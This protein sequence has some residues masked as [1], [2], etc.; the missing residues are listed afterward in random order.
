MSTSD[1]GGGAPEHGQQTGFGWPQAPVGQPWLGG[2]TDRPPWEQPADPGD[3][4][5][6]ERIHPIP[7][8][9]QQPPPPASEP[10]QPVRSPLP[11]AELINREPE[12]SGP[13]RRILGATRAAGSRS[14]EQH[15]PEEVLARLRAPIAPAQRIAVTSV[16][17]GAGKTAVSAL[18]GS[19]LAERRQDPVLALD[20]AEDAGS[21]AWRLATSADQ[22]IPAMTDLAP[23]LRAASGQGL[24]ALAPVLART[25]TGLWV[26]PGGNGGQAHLARDL[27][28]TLAQL[29]AVEVLDCGTGMTAPATTSVLTDAHAV[30]IT[31]P[32]TPDGVRTTLTAL[33]RAPTASLGRVVVALNRGAASGDALA[34]SAAESAFARYSIPVVLL[35]HDRHLAGGTPI[36]P[37][38]VA[39]SVRSAVARLAA[40][41][42][43]RAQ[44]L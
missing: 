28:R 15:E 41:V 13:L 8:P 26:L 6:T 40:Q 2:T 4:E 33:H 36:E 30:V 31:V 19:V 17:G 43:G 22:P 24:G 10:V 39:P 20:A 29:F 11:G 1:S 42:L 38:R 25:A 5:S 27:A 3:P 23:T 44:Q 16:R 35:P 12:N 21:L 14:K 7:N 32:A 18:L 9:Y 34:L 37:D